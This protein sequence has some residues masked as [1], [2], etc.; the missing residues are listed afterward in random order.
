MVY[1]YSYV[2]VSE[3]L[4]KYFTYMNETFKKGVKLF[5]THPVSKTSIMLRV[6][7]NRVIK[8]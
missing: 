1:V 4:N 2:T 8:I 3:N 6:Y 7:S 5:E